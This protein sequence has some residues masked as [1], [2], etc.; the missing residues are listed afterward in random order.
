[1]EGLF[2]FIHNFSNKRVCSFELYLT[3]LLFNVDKR[4]DCINYL[5][6][7]IVYLIVNDYG[8]LSSFDISNEWWDF[9]ELV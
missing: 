2:V 1:M 3:R 9:A 7:L 4:F 5:W 6:L 8:S